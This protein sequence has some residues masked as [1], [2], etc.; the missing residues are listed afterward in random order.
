L[1]ITEKIG[2]NDPCPCGSGRKFK[3]CHGGHGQAGAAS[4]PAA[5]ADKIVRGGLQLQQ[6]GDLDAAESLYMKAI[7][8]APRHPDALHLLGLLMHQRG[9]SREAIVYIEQAIAASPGI[10]E[11]HNNC[12]EA[13]RAAGRYADAILHYRRALQLAPEFAESLVNLGVAQKSISDFS[14]AE[15]SYRAALAKRPDWKQAHANLAN[16]L[17]IQA[18]FAEAETEYKLALSGAPGDLQLYCDLAALL[19]EARD[20]ARA[21]EY[22]LRAKDLAPGNAVIMS[23]LGLAYELQ[24]DTH[25]AI[26]AYRQAVTFDPHSAD[27][28]RNLGFALFN[29]REIALSIDAY[30]RSLALAPEDPNT[31]V[32]LA[33]SL[34][35]A[36]DLP[37]AWREYAWVT[38]Q[39]G[40]IS[41]GEVFKTPEW[42]GGGIEGKSLLVWSEQGI[43]DELW[44]AGMYGDL[45][46]RLGNS[47]RLVVECAPKLAPLLGRSFAAATVVPRQN[48]PHPAAKSADLQVSTVA[49]GEY[50]RARF[51]DFDG[52][53]AYLVADAGRIQHWRQK[54]GAIGP[55]LKVGI[56]W[57][58][59]NAS[60]R[61]AEYVTSLQEW[62]EIVAVSGVQFVNLQYDECNAELDAAELAFAVKVHRYP[63]VD[64]FDDL[65]ETAALIKAL[66][67]VIT[68]PT[69]VAVLSAALGVPTWQ[70]SYIE[71]WRAFGRNMNPWFPTLTSWIRPCDQDW[72]PLLSTVAARLRETVSQTPET[73]H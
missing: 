46:Q 33:F 40:E 61:R 28:L 19:I 73:L 44:F 45:Q 43:G 53:A 47:G 49:L 31:H 52:T 39:H 59:S 8:L 11:F 32:N 3:Q 2:R 18:R 9:N 36:G 55:G 51:E 15:Q 54:L 48:P 63:E 41:R 66:D 21:V 4:P 42:K 29:V 23:N 14:G 71:D 64:M 65:D 38:K 30:E 10:A 17:R 7:A 58:S 26:S 5:S 6:A 62:K 72:E 68:A 13:C 12:G 67:L 27:I 37:R 16:L 69:S 35:S 56:C 34:F 25:N 70:F 20:G 22:L 24:R 1:K 60:G 50:L 57:R